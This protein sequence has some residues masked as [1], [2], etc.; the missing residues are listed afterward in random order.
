MTRRCACGDCVPAAVD[1]SAI[2]RMIAGVRRGAAYSVRVDAVSVRRAIIADLSARG[3]IMCLTL[4]EAYELAAGIRT[5][6]VNRA[7]VAR[8]PNLTEFLLATRN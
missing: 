8:W 3:D 1:S 5:G 7:E 4:E 6:I 2:G